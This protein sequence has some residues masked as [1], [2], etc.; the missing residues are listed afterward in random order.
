MMDG[1]GNVDALP[2]TT[3]GV[4]QLA[5]DWLKTTE[6]LFR[7]FVVSD[8]WVVC[9]S[10]S[11]NTPHSVKGHGL[12]SRRLAADPEELVDPRHGMFFLCGK[13]VREVFYN[14]KEQSAVGFYF[15]PAQAQGGRGIAHG[16]AIFAALDELLGRMCWYVSPFSFTA[17]CNVT[18]RSPCPLF[19]T[20]RCTGRVDRIEQRPGSTSVKVFLVARMESLDGTLV[21]E[22]HAL[23]IQPL[24]ASKPLLGSA[25]EYT[26]RKERNLV[27]YHAPDGSLYTIAPFASRD[28]TRWLHSEIRNHVQQLLSDGDVWLSCRGT[29]NGYVGNPMV[30]T[31]PKCGQFADGKI[32]LAALHNNRTN[33]TT[34]FVKFLYVSEGPPGHAKGGAIATAI[35][36]TLFSWCGSPESEKTE[37]GFHSWGKPVDAKHPFAMTVHLHINYAKLIPL[38]TT[39]KITTTVDSVQ[40]TTDG[41]K[42]KGTLSFKLTSLDGFVVYDTGSALVLTNRRKAF[43]LATATTAT[44]DTKTAKL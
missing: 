44:T 1:D 24:G 36:E 18:F 23:F 35:D 26:A 5:S 25:S 2:L 12:H 17:Y 15:F 11:T 19:E 41:A 27:P 14:V 39:V 38:A 43:K 8:D 22:A 4:E 42:V 40:T 37:L 6:H 3:L 10:N 28:R 32:Q 20:L 29:T 33:V 16:G 34:T 7:P 21:A 9:D 13:E 30:A 31:K